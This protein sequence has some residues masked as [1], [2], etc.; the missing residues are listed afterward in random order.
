M[1]GGNAPVWSDDATHDLF[2]EAGGARQK[3]KAKSQDV[4]SY[5]MTLE[6][7]Y[8]GGLKKMRVTRKVHAYPDAARASSAD[9]FARG[10][11]GSVMMRERSEIIEFEVKPGWRAGTKLTFAGKGDEVPGAPGR[12][13]DLVVV[14]EQTPHAHFTRENDHLVAHARVIP[15]QQALCGVRLTLPGVDGAPVSVSFGANAEGVVLDESGTRTRV[16][17]GVCHPGTR[18]CALGRGMP[19]QK[20]GTRGDVIFVIDSVGFPKTVTEA[21]RAAFKEAFRA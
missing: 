14:I 18:L 17:G 11:T 13:N 9:P 10:G 1:A 20:T 12:A 15:L 2:G 8:A 3:P 19:N 21:Q 4:V 7:L 16:T 5:P 6:A